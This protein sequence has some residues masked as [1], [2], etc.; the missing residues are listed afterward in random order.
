MTIDWID[1]VVLPVR[2]LEEAAA[3]FERLGL[4][5]TAVTRHRGLG[6]ENRA[7]FADS[8][9]N[10]CFVELLAVHD[11]EASLATPRGAAYQRAIDQGVGVARLMLGTSD[12]GE[13][14]RRLAE[15]GTAATVESVFREDGARLCDVVPLD[16]VPGFGIAAG[17]IQY[18]ESRAAI[19]ARRAADGRFDHAFPLARLDHLAAMAPDLEAATRAWSGA[20]GVPVF[21]EVRG[22]GIIIRQMKVGDAIVELLG[23]DGPESR[24]HGRPPGLAS[25]CAF[26]VPDLDAAV[27]TARERGFTCPDPNKG[28]LPGTRV[29]TIPAAELAGLGLQLLEYV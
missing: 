2:S 15:D 23:P 5:L 3:G 1:H 22:P 20:L 9:G 13:M 6:T 25:M 12:L 28:I 4:R 8:G 16:S 17:L 21:G 26:E 11:R 7:L 29:T 10:D 19:H 27:A 14:A 18:P 24:L